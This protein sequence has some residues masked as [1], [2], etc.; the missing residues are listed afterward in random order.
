MASRLIE[1]LSLDENAG[2]Y[3]FDVTAN[4]KNKAVV[5][6]LLRKEDKHF[7]CVAGVY[8]SSKGGDD[9]VWMRLVTR[10]LEGVFD[11]CYYYM[12]QC[13]NVQDKGKPAT[14]KWTKPSSIA[15]LFPVFS[16][17]LSGAYDQL[18]CLVFILTS[19]QTTLSESNH[20]LRLNDSIEIIRNGWT[21]KD[22]QSY[23]PSSHLTKKS[24]ATMVESAVSHYNLGAMGG[25][26]FFVSDTLIEE[27]LSL[28]AFVQ[29]EPN[30]SISVHDRIPKSLIELAQ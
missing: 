3:V 30:S 27:L 16:C 10:S 15:T 23:Q 28:D 14:F 20:S 26:N 5:P 9:K 29:E 8:R 13:Y 22:Y 18:Q 25:Q 11:Y 7:Q 17:L 21:V 24:L 19:F 4:G 1:T 6:I 2:L 12:R